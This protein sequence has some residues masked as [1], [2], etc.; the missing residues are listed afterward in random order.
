[1]KKAF[2]RP[3]VGFTLIEAIMVIVITGIIV[4]MVAMFIRQPIDAYVDTARRASL[5]DIADTTTRYIARDL[6]SALPNSVRSGNPNFLEF[7]PVL[8]AGRYRAEVGIDP[9][10]DPL[11]FGVAD[12]SFDILGPPITTVKGNNLVV[13]NLGIPGADV[14]ETPPTIRFPAMPGSNVT[15]VTYAGGSLTQASP[16][17]R[18]QI[19]SFPVSYVCDMATGTLWRY[20]DYDFQPAQPL[21]IAALNSLG[22]IKAPLATRLSKCQF[23]Y[24]PGPL[25]HNGL[26]SVILSFTRDGETV[27]LQHEVNIDNVP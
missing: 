2:L 20:A 11:L 13:Y 15:K 16:G 6:R 22:A 9:A 4:A 8:V 18:F 19:V 14:Y 24:G 1:M 3:Q 23:A 26:V 17:A 7:V 21:S 27:T 12:N 5:V 10:D 25:Q